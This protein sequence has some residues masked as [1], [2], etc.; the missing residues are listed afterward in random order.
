[1]S[2]T[3]IEWTDKTWNPV[4]GCSRVSPGCQNCYAERIAARFSDPGG[5]FEGFA[6][7]STS[8]G[9]W[10]GRVRLLGETKLREPL[11]WKTPL[12]CFVNSTSD[13][14]HENLLNEEIA[15]VFGV[16][17]ACPHITFQ[18]L[19]KRADR[20]EQWAAWVEREEGARR[21]G[22]LIQHAQ[23]AVSHSALRQTDTL[24]RVPWP[25]PNV[26]LGVSVEDQKRADER[27]PHLIRT[28]AAI[29]FLS[30]EPLIGPVSFCPS[31]LAGY[32]YDGSGGSLRYKPRVDWV[33]A[34][35][36]S[37]PGARPCHVRWIRDVQ[38]ACR[39][40][41]VPCFVK[42]LGA[43]VID[44]NDAGFELDPE[45]P[46]SWPEPVDVEHDVNGFREEFQGADCRVVL[47]DGKGG[48]PEEWPV[49]LRVREFPDV[50]QPGLFDGGA[51]P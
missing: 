7:R 46:E 38:R 11:S 1:M 23:S 36:E 39:D 32:D 6:K 45:R 20:M 34:G 37:G 13:L 43:D 18:V 48:K 12:R 51:Q 29:R 14:F 40:A 10:T 42:Q 50:S 17:A 31:W 3:S 9:R 25:L 27:I 26:W 24:L 19:T 47:R 2:E 41:A 28:P 15:A 21:L 30:V 16:M 33:I 44:R 8:G 22:L 4:R 5:A 49:D 35:G